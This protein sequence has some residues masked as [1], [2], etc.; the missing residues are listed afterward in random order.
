[1]TLPASETDRL[2]RNIDRLSGRFITA[3]FVLTAL[4]PARAWGWGYEGHQIVATIAEARLNPNA[5]AAVKE[6]LGNMTIADAAPSPDDLRKDRQE[7]SPW[8]Y[9]NIPIEA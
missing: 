4:L 9:V 5:L 3:F 1:M 8:R 2:I 6:L 7:T